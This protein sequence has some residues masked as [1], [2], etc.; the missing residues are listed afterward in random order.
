MVTSNSKQ[1]KK[2]PQERVHVEMSIYQ[3]IIIKRKLID[4][5]GSAKDL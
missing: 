2:H 5:T 4:I 1:L 3:I